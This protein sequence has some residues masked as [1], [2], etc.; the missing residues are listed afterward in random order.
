MVE[1]YGFH[2]DSQY[3]PLQIYL[4]VLICAVKYYRCFNE[5]PLCLFGGEIKKLN[6]SLALKF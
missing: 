6:R 1:L 2:I 5:N 4:V 3:Q